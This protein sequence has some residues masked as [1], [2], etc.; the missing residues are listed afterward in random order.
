MYRSEFDRLEEILEGANVDL[1]EAEYQK[2]KTRRYG[3]FYSPSNLRRQRRFG[4]ILEGAGACDFCRKVVEHFRECSSEEMNHVTPDT[5]ANFSFER[6]N[7]NPGYLLR[8]WVSIEI[9]KPS[10]EGDIYSFLLQFQK[11]NQ[12]PLKVEDFCNSGSLFDWEK[13]G[14]EQLFSGR[15]RPLVADTRLL[16][17]WKENCVEKHDNCIS[18]STREQLPWLR[19][20]DVVKRCVIDCFL[21]EKGYCVGDDIG[22]SYAAL[23][24]VWGKY[25]LVQSKKVI[26]ELDKSTEKLFR[27][28]RSLTR[29]MVLSTIDDA[30]E[31][32]QCIGKISLG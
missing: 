15:I 14:P 30:I 10:T 1:Y 16:R 5:I 21:H 7:N 11:C 6:V 19:L 28:P 2:F 13:S 8:L 3:S 25:K 4:S 27:E 29:E 23:S 20:I 18:S 32:A 26:P 24:Y 31:V 9:P 12:Q 22:I 17:K